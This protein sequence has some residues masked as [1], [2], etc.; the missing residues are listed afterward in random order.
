MTKSWQL[1]VL[2]CHP[3][4][5][6]QSALFSKEYRLKKYNSPI[7]ARSIELNISNHGHYT[8]M[9]LDWFEFAF[10]IICNPNNTKEAAL[11][12]GFFYLLLTC[13]TF[14]YWRLHRRKWACSGFVCLV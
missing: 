4:F 8:R 5:G 2:V 9:A 6:W 10:G 7:F 14:L 11:S 12:G 1:L 13:V 3:G